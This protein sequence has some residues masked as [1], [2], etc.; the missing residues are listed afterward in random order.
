MSDQESAPK[1]HHYKERE[2]N[3]VIETH[4]TRLVMNLLQDVAGKR[5]RCLVITRDEETGDLVEANTQKRI[6]VRYM[7]N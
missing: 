7:S 5:K 3:P 1:K 2:G 4:S 6:L